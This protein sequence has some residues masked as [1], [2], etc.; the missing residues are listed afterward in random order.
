MLSSRPRDFPPGELWPLRRNLVVPGLHFRNTLY[1]RLQV[2]RVSDG[3]H[4]TME[5]GRYRDFLLLPCALLPP[6]LLLLLRLLRRRR[7]L[8][9][10]FDYTT[11]LM[12][13]TR[14]YRARAKASTSTMKRHE[15]T[16][17]V[18]VYAQIMM[19]ARTH[20]YVF[21]MADLWA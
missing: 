4:A 13:D 3:S 6:P 21:A 7:Y 16:V 14:H 2:R 1:A 5:K 12:I 18:H 9:F 15:T 20:T 8:P 17:Y 11:K 19:M 10:S